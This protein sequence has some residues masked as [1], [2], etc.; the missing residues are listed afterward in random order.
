[1]QQRKIQSICFVCDITQKKSLWLLTISVNLGCAKY[2][3]RIL[4]SSLI[5]I[6]Q[7]HIAIC[8]IFVQGHP[9]VY[10]HLK[11]LEVWLGGRWSDF[12][13]QNQSTIILQTC[14]NASCYDPSIIRF[15]YCPYNP[16][17]ESEMDKMVACGCWWHMVWSCSTTWKVQCTLI[18]YVPPWE[19]PIGTYCRGLSSSS[20][21][22]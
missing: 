14:W 19:R 4:P 18:L 2:R 5:N 8:E 12:F 15:N 22:G 16:C 7:H 3:E 20:L 10:G 13:C 21:F 9:S 11:F 6:V 17:S 1:M